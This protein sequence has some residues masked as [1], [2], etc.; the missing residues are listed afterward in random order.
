M[1]TVRYSPGS[2]ER[3]LL[4]S[5]L[6]SAE[7]LDF[8]EIRICRHASLGRRTLRKLRLLGQMGV[9]RRLGTDGCTMGP[10]ADREYAVDP[11]GVD[12]MRPSEMASVRCWPST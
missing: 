2:N 11:V 7:D 5:K 9:R 3:T 12:T 1:L 8:G 10:P 4:P 6:S